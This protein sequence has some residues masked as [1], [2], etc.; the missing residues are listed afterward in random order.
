M[1]SDAT[2]REA[3]GRRDTP[4]Q[5]PKVLGADV[6]LGNFVEGVAVSE[7]TGAVASRVLL[8][9]I[10]G[11]SGQGTEPASAWAYVSPVAA[12]AQDWGRKFLP[13][14]AACVYVDLDHL[15]IASPETL[16]AFDHVAQGRA[17]LGIARDAMVRV[18]QQATPGRR[19]Q[20]LANCSDGLGHSYG[21]HTN[22]LLTRAAWDNIIWRRPHYAAYLIAFQASSIVFTGQGKVGSE[23]D[24]AP[25]PFQLSQR[26]D[27]I[28]TLL[29]QETTIHRPIVNSRDEPLCGTRPRVLR[30]GDDPELA[31][32]HVIFFDN[33]LC[34]VASLLRAGVLQIVV[35]LIEA[36]RV[37]VALALDDPLQALDHWSHDPSLRARARTTTG[38]DVTAVEMQRGFLDDARTFAAEG[39][40]EGIVP[41]AGDILATWADT[42]DRLDAR[43]FPALA[44]R[45][46]WVLKRQI[47]ERVL[48][49][50][51]ALTWASPEIKHLD[52]M[53]AS[54]DEQDGLFWP[55]ERAGLVDRVVT[56][57]AIVHARHHPPEDTR[58][59]TR[60]HLLRLADGHHAEIDQVDWDL[61]R[62]RLYDRSG[63]W[64]RFDRRTIRLP[65]P[66]GS[67]RAQ[68]EGVF[69]PDRTLDDVVESLDTEGMTIS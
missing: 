50:R 16:S 1:T 19:V 40:F 47:L 34:Q 10:A 15:E 7:G 69:G 12:N 36:G 66:F 6:E 32:L 29:S 57:E 20:V 39:G 53:F 61:V 42:L 9:E 60:A 2:S 30:A 35:A 27:F 59:W 44:R 24:R 49:K 8:R 63:T 67:T 25:V 17:M 41:R 38:A 13:G 43:D 52:Q 58:A 5:V 26:A 4:P 22:V 64:P 46:D 23:N 55:C 18:N 3:A 14:N 45:L 21:S 68:N 62:V 48:A 51:P 54:L 28:E 11:I 37:N 31:R 56:D 33:T 65:N